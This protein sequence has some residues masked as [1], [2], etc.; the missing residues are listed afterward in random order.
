MKFKIL[1]DNSNLSLKKARKEILCARN[2]K[3]RNKAA[4][5]LSD[6]LEQA[7]GF[8]VGGGLNY[9]SRARKLL[10][11]LG[12]DVV[13]LKR[14]LNDLNTK[15]KKELGYPLTPVGDR[16]HRL[17]KKRNNKDEIEH[18]NTYDD[19]LNLEN[20]LSSPTKGL[21][22]QQELK[23]LSLDDSKWDKRRRTSKK[24]PV[25]MIKKNKIY[26]QKM[27]EQRWQEKRG[28]NNI[29]VGTFGSKTARFS[30]YGSNN[31]NINT[32]NNNEND[33]YLSNM[34]DF[35]NLNNDNMGKKTNNN[36][37]IKKNITNIKNIVPSLKKKKL[38][39]IQNVP[40]SARS[41]TTSRSNSS[42]SS[43]STTA[44]L[45]N[46]I[47]DPV[48]KN[49]KKKNNVHINSILF[50]DRD[51]NKAPFIGTNDTKPRLEPGIPFY[52]HF[53]RSSRTMASC[54]ENWNY[55]KMPDTLIYSKK[56]D[57]WVWIYNTPNEGMRR[58]EFTNNE[59]FKN[60]MP[61]FVTRLTTV[62]YPTIHDKSV[63][64]EKQ[65]PLAILS[66][67]HEDDVDPDTTNIIKEPLYNNAHVKG[68]ILEIY[69]RDEESKKSIY[70]PSLVVIQKFTRSITS[71]SN[72]RMKMVRAVWKKKRQPQ[73]YVVENKNSI[74]KNEKGYAINISS[75]NNNELIINKLIGKKATYVELA[76][77]PMMN[78]LE[79]TITQTNHIVLKD[80]VADFQFI[81]TN[82]K[83]KKYLL[84]NIVAFS[85]DKG[86]IDTNVFPVFRRK[87]R[88][89]NKRPSTTP[90]KRSISKISKDIRR[91][92]LVSLKIKY[93]PADLNLDKE[94]IS[95][96]DYSK[97]TDDTRANDI[98]NDIY[99]KAKAK[100]TKR[101]KNISR[102]RPRTTNGAIVHDGI[103]QL[104]NSSL[105][106][107]KS[108]P[109]RFCDPDDLNLHK[110]FVQMPF[111]I[112][113]FEHCA[114]RLR[115][116][117]RWAVTEASIS[118]E[119]R[120]RLNDTV[121]V[122]NE[123]HN[124]YTNREV[125]RRELKKSHLNNIFDDTKTDFINRNK[126][127]NTVISSIKMA[128]P[129]GWDSEEDENS[130]ILNPL[131]VDSIISEHGV[132]DETAE[133]IC[134]ICFEDLKICQCM[135]M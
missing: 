1:E 18:V 39:K 34:N 79:K 80:L 8:H 37:I 90:G 17:K 131:N 23:M 89:N 64:D 74:Q 125:A 66:R 112:L 22:L 41:S 33:T 3:A 43:V 9:R 24:T 25:N 16:L 99:K 95:R 117:K 94:E 5:K 118:V 38:E 21:K 106:T 47:K 63:K 107:E 71:A 120:Y 127:I 88:G 15:R 65:F 59:E 135:K 108:C 49:K 111:K 67:Y 76:L 113:A 32:R 104:L 61:A 35:L 101:S 121:Y 53:F 82:D 51:Y 109:G 93:L 45:F 50:N 122:C 115:P 11:N 7:E 69:D 57:S 126:K 56:K 123:C 13:N 133:D 31:N 40:Y 85:A 62:D 92:K 4:M 54:V 91:A 78:E 58:L 2:T 55:I 20:T 36:D 81:I 44:S 129:T 84:T 48:K 116:S 87:Y 52:K 86:G 119:D 130:I 19:D 6:K 132:L 46:S 14:D 96:T 27:E 124:E 105:S 114:S 68:A 98:L 128:K 42:N 12:N 100:T 83:N 30:S 77:T 10:K 110:R 72:S 70:S 26:I 97:Y 102:R 28:K 73:Y 29:H 103:Q 75:H 134:L 60:F